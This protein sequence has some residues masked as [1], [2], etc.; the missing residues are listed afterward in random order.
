MCAV[1]T[2]SV[3]WPASAGDRFAYFLDN[4]TDTNLSVAVPE[5]T[6]VIGW[7]TQAQRT[8]L[9]QAGRV[10]GC[11]TGLSSI[12]GSKALWHDSGSSPDLHALF[13]VETPPDL[14]TPAAR[15]AFAHQVFAA[16]GVYPGAFP[17]STDPGVP[18]GNDGYV[19]WAQD[20]EGPLNVPEET[21]AAIIALFWAGRELLG[22]NM[23]V[24]PVPAS[25]I[26]KTHASV[27]DLKSVVGGSVGDNYVKFLNIGSTLSAANQSALAGNQSIDLL[28]L[29]HLCT[30]EG[31]ALIDG[32]LAQQYSASHC[33]NPEGCPVDCQSINC[34]ALP[35]QFSSD[36]PAL[37]DKTLPYAIMSA[38]DCPSQ[39]FLAPPTAGCPGITDAAAPWE[40]FYR[41]SMPFQAGVYWDQATIDPQ[42]VFDPAHYLIPTRAS[43]GV[44]ESLC[45]GDLSHDGHVN[46]ADLASML[47]IWGPLSN[48][49][50]ADLNNDMAVGAE[51]LLSLLAHWGECP[52]G[53]TSPWIRVL[54][55][56]EVPPAPG[57]EMVTYV[58][59]IQALA[60]ALE[61]IHL[62]FAA[63]ATN[64]QDYATLIGL[65][66]LAYGS[67]LAI[68]FHPDN[69]HSSCS[70][71]G[72]SI[73]TCPP[74]PLLC[75][76][77]DSTTWQCVLSKSIDAMNTINAIVDPT[78]SGV[79]FTIFSLEQS[80]VED[81]STG[82]SQCPLN[83]L[84]P[85]K[86]T[87]AGSSTA[88]PG[89]TAAS[90]PVKFGNVLP[91]Y[92]GPDIYGADG[93]DFG[94]PQAYNLGKHLTA[95]FGSLVTAQSP[96]F[97][98]FS[99]QGCLPGGGAFPCW[100]VDVD[101]NAAYSQPKIP[102]FDPGNAP[103]V[104]TYV[105]PGSSGPSPTLAAAYVSF[106]MTQ[107]PPISNIVPLS[108]SDVYMTFSGE[109]AFLGAPGWTLANI[110]A[111]HSALM[112]NFA[113]LKQLAPGL[114][115]AT[116]GADP[117]TLKFAIWNFEPILPSIPVD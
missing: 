10:V 78:H 33:S 17:S 24:I 11:S 19:L 95:E 13:N 75:A 76:P 62:R 7:S 88:L 86:L 36:T 27:W 31:H 28:S 110:S 98:A 14:S 91:S 34:T 35:G 46:A 70:W 2:L 99:A 115:P 8:Q 114:F 64:Y 107:Y 26:Q 21:A 111:F 100:V 82:T 63:G 12:G 22:P 67:S 4:F 65:L 61:Q 54:I 38:H 105:E 74:D 72:C 55:A 56:E 32:I 103:N 101:S 102:C 18:T 69:S 29:L 6:V 106:L 117:D 42:T 73:D 53:A 94:Y 1:M 96:Y 90:P 20:I 40:S 59:R 41:G 25:I 37:F 83:W 112:N 52:L 60:P 80:S 113:T 93:Y 68:G 89:V 85:I 66:R 92:G 97:P 116:G 23:A 108:G 16:A 44:G 48:P 45:A 39:L 84:A 109:P 71:W 47:S 81:V 5:G 58:K 50:A 87:L 43:N 77:T 15:R 79:G 3:A 9:V 104:Y 49:H 51:D 30:A 57:A